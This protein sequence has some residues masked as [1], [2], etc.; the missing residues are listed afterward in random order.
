MFVKELRDKSNIR[1]T[2]FLQMKEDQLTAQFLISTNKWRKQ[3][4]CLVLFLNGN[5]SGKWWTFGA[6]SDLL[7]DVLTDSYKWSFRASVP[8]NTKALI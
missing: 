5:I 6:I 1:T 4:D 3:N 2:L 8:S 7:Q